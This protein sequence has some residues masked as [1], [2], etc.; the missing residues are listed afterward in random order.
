MK[1]LSPYLRL[2]AVFLPFFYWTFLQAADSAGTTKDTP[3]I[4]IVAAFQGEMDAIREEIAGEE[5]TEEVILNGV[6]SSLGTAY[7]KPV[8]FFIT[9]VSTV[10]AAM[11]TQ[12]ALDRFPIKMLLFSGI[13]GGISW[14]LRKGDVAIPAKWHYILEGA[15]FNKKDDGSGQY[16]SDTMGWS[17]HEYGNFGMI[18]P[19]NVRAIRQ[20]MEKPQKM[21]FFEAD[22]ELLKLSRKATAQLNLKNALGKKATIKIGGVGGTSP[23]FLDN[24]EFRE[25][26]HQA[27]GTDCVD[28]E[29]TC[30]AHVCWVNQVPCLIVRSLS[31]LA[32]GQKGVNEIREYAKAAEHN[33]ARVL[34]EILKSLD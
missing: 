21:A 7:G 13:A 28:M 4:A 22:P 9:H 18:H 30:I 32:G 27:W 33:A 12:L 29:S 15:L 10:N 2:A 34:N 23:A 17:T 16:E 5:I 11:N 25:F 31:D 24:A 20:G 26:I 14:D 19:E 6:K 8:L 3:R 1:T